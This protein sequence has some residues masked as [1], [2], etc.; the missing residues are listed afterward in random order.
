MKNQEVAELLD[1]VAL[2]LEASGGDRFKV[3]AYRRAS[4]TVRNLEED[5]EDVW[6]SGRLG[7]LQYVGEAI[8]EKVST[9]LETG[10]LPYL[11]KLE[12]TVPEGAVELMKIPGVG[13][14]TAFKL[15]KNHGVKTVEQ[16]KAELSSG[17]LA[18]VLGPVMSKKILESINKLQVAQQRIL[19]AEALALAD[20]LVQYFMNNGIT[21]EPAGSLRRGKSTVGDIDILASD[22][23]ASGAFVSY[24]GVDRVLESGPTRSSV[25]L[26]NG[27]QVDLRIIEREGYG[28]ALMYFTGS[29]E[30]NIALR[31]LAIGKSWKL[32]EYGLY[33]GKSERRIAGKS[34]EEV[35]RKLGLAFIPPELRENRGEIEAAKKGRIPA[36]IKVDSIRGDLQMH[37]TW[38]DGVDSL[39]TMAMAAKQMGYEYVAFTDHSASVRIANGLSEERFRKQWKEIDQL[40]EKLAPFR[41]LKGVEAEIKG[42]GSLDS[43]KKFFDEF[44]IVGAS[45]HQGYNQSPEKLTMRAVGALSHPSVDFLCHP[46]NRLIGRREGH[47][48]DMPKII[49]AAR[50]NGKMLEIDG[51]PNRLDLD[52]VWA[53]AAMEEGVALT[54][55]SDAHSAGELA[56][57][58]FGAIVGRRAWLESKHVAN[59]R[60]LK[61]ILRLLA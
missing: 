1:R 22:D 7:D 21:V 8:S 55:D 50:D 18:S 11:D 6:K 27:T 12:K 13:P 52:D 23:K 43:D 37:S 40:N 38:S 39:E 20:A 19:L 25:I 48:L 4:N 54:I 34:E 2:L 29:K 14:R 33:E 51:Q 15:S 42:D 58:T 44:D 9:Y 3:I 31:N 35:Y 61:D 60:P 57:I 17:K 30:H 10:A 24:P 47:A 32:N 59:T 26:K 16:L 41:I 5:I 45:I 53:K 49:N 46:T 56:N 36:I 28:A